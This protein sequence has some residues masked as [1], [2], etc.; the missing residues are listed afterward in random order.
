[1]DEGSSL[2]MDELFTADDE[3]NDV[4]L[5]LDSFWKVMGS[6]TEPSQVNFHPS[7]YMVFFYWAYLAS[8]VRIVSTSL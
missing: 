3:C 8:V 4:F 2:I 6:P 7:V 5:D 1:M